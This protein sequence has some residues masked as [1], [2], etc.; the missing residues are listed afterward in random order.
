VRK[1]KEEKKERFPSRFRTPVGLGFEFADL[2]KKKKGEAALFAFLV[3]ETTTTTGTTPN[4]LK[5]KPRNE[6][7]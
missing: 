1:R 4:A 5:K 6:N 2:V 3:V 7:V